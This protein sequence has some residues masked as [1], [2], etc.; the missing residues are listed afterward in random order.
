MLS[1]K[2]RRDLRSRANRLATTITIA[3]GEIST[4]VIDHVREAFKRQELL[5]IRVQA[6]DAK[7]CD[8]TARRLADAVPCEWI[9]RVGRVVVLYHPPNPSCDEAASDAR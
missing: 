4:S 1:P 3:S 5:K 6:D 2:Q 9:G 7:S 8:H